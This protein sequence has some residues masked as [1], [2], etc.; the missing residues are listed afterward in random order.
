MTAKSA[1]CKPVLRSSSAKR[2]PCKIDYSVMNEKLT[3]IVLD[4]FGARKAPPGQDGVTIFRQVLSHSE[5]SS[6]KAEPLDF[7][8]AVSQGICT[9]FSTSWIFLA[10]LELI[11]K[12]TSQRVSSVINGD[13]SCY[14]LSHGI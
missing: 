14:T 2:N 3:R 6:V 5:L 1:K 10:L 12:M 9:S 8:R 11:P 13:H 7:T 4:S